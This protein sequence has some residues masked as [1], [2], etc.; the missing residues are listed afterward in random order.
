MRVVDTTGIKS[1]NEM[2]ARSVMVPP[3]YQLELYGDDNWTG[4]RRTIIGDLESNRE[5][6]TKYK[7]QNIPMMGKKELSLTWSHGSKHFTNE[8]SFE[9][10]SLKLQVRPQ[11]VM[12]GFW[13]G[14]TSTGN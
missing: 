5:S 7:C 12:T 10:T 4:E 3:D 1:Y 9:P 6:A 14:I 2:V 11:G 13:K 8:Y